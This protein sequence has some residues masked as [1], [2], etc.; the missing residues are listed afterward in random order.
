MPA[1]VR[2]TSSKL[3]SG[4]NVLDVVAAD[5]LLETVVCAKLIKRKLIGVT[6]A[7]LRILNANGAAAVLQAKGGRRADSGEPSIS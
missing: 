7:I 1:N 5:Q 3:G 4:V 6:C 2:K